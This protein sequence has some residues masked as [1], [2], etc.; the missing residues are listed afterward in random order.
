MPDESQRTL[1]LN[2]FRGAAMLI[3]VSVLAS[4]IIGF[5]REMI[6]A[7]QFGA[8]R[9][10]DAYVVAFTI[11]DLLNYLVAGGALA[12]TFIP[13]LGGLMERG[14]DE[15]GRRVLSIVATF[16]GLILMAGTV[17][18]EIFAPQILHW[19][20]PE[21]SPQ[22]IMECVRMTRILIPGPLFFCLGGLLSAV[23]YTRGSFLVP[24]ITPLIYNLSTIVGAV[25]L[26]NRLGVTSLA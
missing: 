22:Q 4:R 25:L 23:L 17:I 19:Y 26:G 15:E 6:I 9:N 12:I 10:T 18:T 20:K 14:E 24:A 11:P 21:W 2:Q 8:N 7:W 16:M 1:R 5:V 3:M 13:I